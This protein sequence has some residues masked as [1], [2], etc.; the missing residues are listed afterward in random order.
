MGGSTEEPAY[1]SAAKWHPDSGRDGAGDPRVLEEAEGR[2]GELKQEPASQ[3]RWPNRGYWGLQ[4][5]KETLESPGCGEG[6]EQGPDSILVAVESLDPGA[7][8]RA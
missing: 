5:G 6:L 3:L 4:Q 2:L 8:S 1:M 7:L